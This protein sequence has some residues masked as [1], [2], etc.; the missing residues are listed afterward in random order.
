VFSDLYGVTVSRLY[1][2]LHTHSDP[3]RLWSAIPAHELLAK[4]TVVSE[5]A[6]MQLPVYGLRRIPLLRG[7]VKKLL[8]YCRAS[9]RRCIFGR[10]GELIH[11]ER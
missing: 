9:Y 5:G 1:S 4:R 11:R 8:R 6:T 10:D 3:Y 7:W 2:T